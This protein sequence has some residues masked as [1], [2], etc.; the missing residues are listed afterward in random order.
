MNYFLNYL[1]CNRY[2]IILSLIDLLHLMPNPT[3]FFPCIVAAKKQLKQEFHLILRRLAG[4][5]PI[6]PAPISQCLAGVFMLLF[7]SAL[8]S[9]VALRVPKIISNGITLNEMQSASPANKSR[10]RGDNKAWPGRSSVDFDVDVDAGTGN[11]EWPARGIG[12][13]TAPGKKV[14]NGRGSRRGKVDSRQSA[15]A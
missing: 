6:R 15:A 4:Q 9:K 5:F 8:I 3:L 2:K 12:P 10:P 14:E 7:Y 11:P 13:A 1:N